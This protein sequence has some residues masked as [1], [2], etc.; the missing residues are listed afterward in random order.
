MHTWPFINKK[1]VEALVGLANWLDKN[2]YKRESLTWKH[3][4]V[5]EYLTL[6]IQGYLRNIITADMG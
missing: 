6:L 3:S 5:K 2:L 1:H 4:E